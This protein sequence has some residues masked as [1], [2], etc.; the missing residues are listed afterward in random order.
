MHNSHARDRVSEVSEVPLP[1]AVLFVDGL[2]LVLVLVRQM[3]E[4]PA[5]SKGEKVRV[6]RRQQGA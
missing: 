2:V 1:V 6:G 3:R 4:L 5:R